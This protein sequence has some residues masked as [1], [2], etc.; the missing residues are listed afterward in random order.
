MTEKTINLETI[1]DEII[2]ASGVEIF[3]PYKISK[4]MNAIIQT[5]DPNAKDLPPQM[6]YQYASKGMLNGTKK[7]IRFTPA[8]VRA[9]AIK[10]LNKRFSN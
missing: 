8:E 7:S 6:F 5:V 1:I 3:S 10:Y 9:F 2:T 4:V